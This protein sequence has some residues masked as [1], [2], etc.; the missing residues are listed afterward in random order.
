[1]TGPR[2]DD[3]NDSPTT[4]FTAA[5]DQGLPGKEP[6]TDGLAY[7]EVPETSPD[8]EG[9]ADFV[10]GFV[11]ASRPSAYAPLSTGDFGA[12]PRRRNH[13]GLVIG[14][15]LGIALLVAAGILVAA[16]PFE[17]N[18]DDAPTTTT[19][20]PPSAS[21]PTPPATP[22]HRAGDCLRFVSNGVFESSPCGPTGGY[23]V[24]RA[25]TRT[26]GCTP[27]QAS[28]PRGEFIY[29]LDLDVVEGSCYRFL[30]DDG[31]VWVK[32]AA[33]GTGAPAVLRQFRGQVDANLCTD[34]PGATYS[35]TFV[36]PARVVCV[37]A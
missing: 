21:S 23:R 9:E 3:A 32:P 35:Y 31:V 25:V 15:L 1:M 36:S 24:Q 6:S 12:Q 17:W 33:C 13:A 22:E 18:A 29:C 19:Q 8:A 27:G 7:S 10:D 11:P 14:T 28:L 2:S 34:V 26:A 20:T 4:A 30:E 16:D 5:R 37:S